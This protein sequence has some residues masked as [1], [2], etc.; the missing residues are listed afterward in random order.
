MGKKFYSGIDLASQR[1][2]NAADP[3]G[4]A[5]LATKSYVDNLLAGLRWKAPVRVATTTNGT[6]ASA[7]ANGS[8]VDGVTLATGDRILLK[9]QTTATENGV[10][11]VNASGAPTRAT[12]A[13]ST[14]EVHGMTVMVTS[15]TANADKAFTQTTDNPTL[16]SSNLVFVQI[17]GGS[18]YLA[19]GNGIELS[20]V[21]FSIELD[22]T[23]L[24]KGANGIRIGSGAAASGGGLTESSGALSVNTGT[25]LEKSSGAVRL[26]TQGTGIAG[27]AGSVLSIDTSVVVRKYAQDSPSLSAGTPATIT[28]NLN[29]RDVE[30]KIY[31]GTTGTAPE[32]EMDVAVT[33]VNTV[34]V[35]SAG[36]QSAAAF[37]IV[38]F[39]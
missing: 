5:D 19:D 3:T 1:A 32:V 35:T 25:G 37:R 11:T 29:T 28:H 23:T 20:G 8:T 33:G 30:V 17:G 34:T 38:V 10:Y 16:G 15:G 39:G 2:Q 7:Y 21:T 26:A 18:S 27:G 12:D 6:L 22:G 31:E 24:T 4:P 9:D 14:A 13:D 36:A